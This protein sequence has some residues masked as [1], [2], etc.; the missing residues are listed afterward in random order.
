MV[1]GS[2]SDGGVMMG[3]GEVRRKRAVRVKR[4]VV[5]KGGEGEGGEET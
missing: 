2:V 1:M 3:N 4:Q 5:G